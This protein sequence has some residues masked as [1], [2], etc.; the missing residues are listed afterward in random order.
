MRTLIILGLVAAAQAPADLSKEKFEAYRAVIKPEPG[1][2]HLWME[3]PWEISVQDARE[4]AARED[5]PLLLF[6]AA[7]GHPLGHS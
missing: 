7:N 4:R 6:R 2:Q 3:I 5:K 1:K